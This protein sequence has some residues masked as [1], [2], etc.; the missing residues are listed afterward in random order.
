MG[1]DGLYLRVASNALLVAGHEMG[2]EGDHWP[3]I[4]A[5][6]HGITN[7]FE[8]LEI[9]EDVSGELKTHLGDVISRYEALAREAPEE[10]ARE[11]RPIVAEMREVYDARFAAVAGKHLID[12]AALPEGDRFVPW[13]TAAHIIEDMEK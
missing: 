10:L 5:A 12:G 11:L 13:R 8:A 7:E 1:Q 6:I 4:K 2:T 3:A 9:E